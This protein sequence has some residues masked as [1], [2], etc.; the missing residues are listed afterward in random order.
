VKDKDTE[1]TKETNILLENREVIIFTLI[2][3]VFGYIIL[4][5]F[6]MV[7][8]DMI[9]S[10]M[11]PDKV[12]AMYA[13]PWMSIIEVFKPYL[14]VWGLIFAVFCGIAGY[15]IGLYIKVKR[16]YMN[17]LNESYRKLQALEQFKDSFTHMIVHDLNNHLMSISGRLQL[18]KMEEENF[19][20]EQKESLNSAL[21]A[22]KDL[23]RMISNLLD[24]NKMEEG[25]L[26]LRTEEFRLEDI[27]AEVIKEMNII[28]RKEEVSVSLDAALD[29]PVI[30]ADKDL[31]TRVISNLISNAIKHS[32]SK[33]VIIV[34]VSFR[35]DD[36][37][38]YI[39]VKDSGK[40]IPREY[41]DKIFDKFVQVEDEEAKM[42]RGL[43]LAFCK[44]AV[45]AHGGKIWVESEAEKGSTFH[46]T[47]PREQVKQNMRA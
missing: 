10:K 26:T 24:I 36:N 38:F 13:K 7:V 9:H 35:Q 1:G 30:L 37:N 3:A 20:E 23:K 39:Q 2:G 21:L 33:G 15:V 4:S 45:E 43:G 34:K 17:K 31:I 27:V 32:P 42:G 28:A 16:S 11:P 12:Q 5:P 29:M 47:I 25:K 14:V 18:L 46:F 6:A 44:M 22:S 19:S 40:G 8:S 41:L